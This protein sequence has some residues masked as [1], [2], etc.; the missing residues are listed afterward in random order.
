MQDGKTT[1]VQQHWEM[2]FR[3]W[4]GSV[5]H[6]ALLCPVWHTSSIP[7]SWTY[8]RKPN[9]NGVAR[10]CFSLVQLWFWHR[11]WFWPGFPVSLSETARTIKI[12]QVGQRDL[13]SCDDDSLKCFISKKKMFSRS[14]S[15]KTEAVSVWASLQIRWLSCFLSTC[16]RKSIHSIIYSFIHS[17]IYSFIY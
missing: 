11:N 16:S 13:L 17:L 4:E 8:Y 9:V 15:K 7:H 3:W 10:M 2:H 5:P 14:N 12:V 6:M 1:C